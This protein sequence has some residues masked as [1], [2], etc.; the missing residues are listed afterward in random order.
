M[1][2]KNAQEMLDKLSYKKKNVFEEASAE[3]IKE[4]YEYSKGYMKFLD[5][6]KTER[7]AVITTIEMIEKQGYTEY[8]FGDK[9]AVGDKKY[10]NNNG[11]SLVMFKI[12]TEKL[13]EDGIRILASH[14]DSPRIDLK[15]VPLY[16]DAGMGFL[17]THYYGGVKKYQWTAIPLAL[18]GVMVKADGEVVDVKIGVDENYQSQGIGTSLIE[19]I[20]QHH[21]TLTLAVY[22]KNE[23]ALQFYSKHGFAV[24]EERINTRTGEK[25]L[26]MRW[27]RACPI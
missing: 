2:K 13:E 1:E 9:L 17:K 26:L 23:K 14:I 7:E 22:K 8:K 5:D 10:Y 4:I 27:N 19:F 15:Q 11:K 6:A 3:E 18:H 12:G 25:E 24:T 20:K 21:F 16:E